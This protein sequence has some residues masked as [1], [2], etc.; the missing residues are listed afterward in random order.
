[1]YRA[2]RFYTYMSIYCKY[3]YMSVNIDLNLSLE[4]E[5]AE[6]IPV[7]PY[8]LQREKDKEAA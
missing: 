2:L 4:D 1:M 8:D 7:V 3:L 5:G 6:H